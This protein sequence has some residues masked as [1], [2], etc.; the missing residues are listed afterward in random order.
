M[1]LHELFNLLTLERRYDSSELFLHEYCIESV[2]VA[3]GIEDIQL[4]EAKPV[5]LA[6]FELLEEL[7]LCLIVEICVLDVLNVF[8]PDS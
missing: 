2:L 1:V 4:R 5:A 3:K 8:D 6:V 7:R